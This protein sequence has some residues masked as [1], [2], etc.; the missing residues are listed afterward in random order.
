[1]LLENT[2]DSYFCIINN[3]VS[4]GGFSFGGAAATKPAEAAATPAPATTTPAAKTGGF[5]FG[6]TDTPAPKAPS[7]VNTPA[8]ASTPASKPAFTTPGGNDTAAAG[9]PEMIEPPPIEYQSLSVEQIL[10]RFQSELETDTIAFLQEAQRIA[11]YDATLRDSHQSLSEL[12]SMVSRLMIHQQEVDTQLQGVG[13]YHKE[14]ATTLDQLEQNVDEL[15]AAQSGI[16]VQDVD[17]QRERAYERALE[18]DSKLG[19]M[20]NVL[21]NVMGELNAAQ[22]RVWSMARGHDGHVNDEV[23]KIIGVFNSHNET[24]AQLEAKARNL[25]AD[26]TMVGQVLARSGH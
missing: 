6:G 3:V 1:M 13:S 23:G 21:E 19:Q 24:L 22:E 11:H 18:V 2:H 16:S 14:L 5:S 25:E 20:N 7:P 17:I 10:N 15:F 4:I 12:A 26:V 8:N 9:K